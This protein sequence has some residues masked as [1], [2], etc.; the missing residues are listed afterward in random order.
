MKP[1]RLVFDALLAAVALALFIV[2]LQ[3][4]APVPIPGVKLG[5]ANIV[6][7]V[8]IFLLSPLDA[9]AIL[10]VR[11]LLGSLFAGNFMALMYSAVGGLLC[12]VAMLGMRKV[13]TERQVWV[14]SVI[15]AIAHNVGQ[16]AVAIA[17]TQTGALIVYLPVLLISGMIAGLFTGLAAQF[18][19]GRMKPLL[20]RWI[21][22]TKKGTDN[23][24]KHNES[25]R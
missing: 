25:V 10:F 23:G 19:I 9:F 21:E 14:C 12:Y 4:P 18:P 16:M 5:L 24:E 17:V 8:A 6:T 11:I 1:K 22:I 7:V 13:V 2:E 20:P 3:I 15:G